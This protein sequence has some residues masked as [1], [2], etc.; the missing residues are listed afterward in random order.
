MIQIQLAMSERAVQLLCLRGGKPRHILDLGCGSGLSGEILTEH[1]HIWTGVDI[2]SAMLGIL[3]FKA[4]YIMQLAISI[5][6]SEIAK[7]REVEGELVLGDLGQG[8]PFRAGAFD[9]AISISALQ[10]LCHADKASHNPAKSLQKLFS[11]LHSCLVHE[12]LRSTI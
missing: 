7:K 12:F 9:G 3:L 6:L 5:F 1:N 8:L 11:S 2:S 10:W 4:M